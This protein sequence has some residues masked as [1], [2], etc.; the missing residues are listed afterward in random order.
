[1]QF[2]AQ[3]PHHGG[4]KWERGCAAGHS[5]SAQKQFWKVRVTTCCTSRTV[6]SAFQP[7]S[8]WFQRSLGTQRKEDQWVYNVYHP[9]VQCH[10]NSGTLDSPSTSGGGVGRAGGRGQALPLRG[11]LLQ[12]EFSVWVQGWNEHVMRGQLRRPESPPPS[13]LK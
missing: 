1:M 12:L 7:P 9:K 11:Q 3:A 5:G 13:S 10:G 8:R 4:F 6:L 2:P